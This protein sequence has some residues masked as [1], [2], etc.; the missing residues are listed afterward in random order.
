MKLLLTGSSGF[1]GQSIIH[2][3]K[4]NYHIITRKRND[5]FKI[6]EDVV[7]HLAGIA[8]DLK[9][10]IN[11]EE[12]YNVNCDYTKTI[13]DKFLNSNSKIFIYFSSVKAV[14]D[15]CENVLTED[16]PP[17]PMTHYGKS[18]LFA[19]NYI[20]S[21]NIPENKKVYILR[22]CMVH[23]PGN[24]GNLNQ[25]FTF[26]NIL[27]FWPLG[28]FENK[29]SY[30]SIWNLL[31]IVEEL[32]KGHVDSGIYN[33]SDTNTISTNN[34]IIMMRSIMNKKYFK[35][36]KIPKTFIYIVA[37]IGT[38]LRLIFNQDKLNKL[39]E[40]YIVSNKKI[41]KAI[42]KELPLDAK[43]GMQKTLESFKLKSFDIS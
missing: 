10:V 29:R 37:A 39:T 18:K 38:N 3:F 42:H 5:E 21:Q 14:S 2:R 9:N 23:G 34:L 11:P 27:P 31:F 35:I 6:N 13:F 26:L 22:P 17:N 16:T 33:I 32:F 41:I 40:S 43:E 25:L 20:Q 4:D 30:C 8:H 1:I 19:E 15:K 36:I 7:I 28:S 24:K 12:Y